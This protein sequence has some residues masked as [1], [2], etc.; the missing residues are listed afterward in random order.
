[1][2]QSHLAACPCCA[3]HVRVSEAACPFCHSVHSDAFRT[4]PARQPPRQRLTRAA[5]FALGT[6]G[7]VPA[8]SSLPRDAQV[9]SPDSATS[10]DR[11]AM[12]GAPVSCESDFNSPQCGQ[13][14]YGAPC[15]DPTLCEPPHSIPACFPDCGAE[16]TDDSGSRDS[17]DASL[18]DAGDASASDATAS[19]ASMDADA[20][21]FFS[22]DAPAYGVPP[23]AF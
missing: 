17:G 19:D 18:S 21:L 23:D 3:R 7:A 16:P 9:G 10:D 15:L 20:D 22:T 5:L 8:C 6:A 14:S 2:S 12:D 4:T 13:P 1:M 11:E